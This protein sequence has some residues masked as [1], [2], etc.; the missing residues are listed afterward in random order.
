MLD[1]TPLG[2][3]VC[4]TTGTTKTD[5]AGDKLKR[6]DWYASEWTCPGHAGRS[7]V[8]AHDDQ[9]EGLAF[10]KVRTKPAEFVWPE[11]FGAWGPS[12]EWR[13]EK[14]SAATATTLFA[15]A[16][17]ARDV[18]PLGR[19]PPRDLGGELAVIR[20]GPDPASTCILAWVDTSANKDATALARVFADGDAT[21]LHCDKSA[22]PIRLGKPGQE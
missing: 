9:R 3:T 6:R 10:P 12:I 11:R 4:K 22:K 5:E 2:S 17:Y 15:I 1:Q 8:I 20:V 18:G 16:R 19:K 13:G 14:S 7:V 21:R